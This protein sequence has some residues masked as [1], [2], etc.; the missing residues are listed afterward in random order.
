MALRLAGEEFSV[1]Q[2]LD[3][4]GWLR[5]IRANDGAPRHLGEAGWRGARL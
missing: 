2:G 1:V 5:S 4:L 3:G